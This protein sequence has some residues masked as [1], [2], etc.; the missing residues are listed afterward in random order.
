[1]SSGASL[2][3][4]CDCRALAC[5]FGQPAQGGEGNKA[6]AKAHYEKG[7]RLYEIREYDK[8][9]LEYKSAYLAQPDPAF[10]STSASAIESSARTKRRSISFGNT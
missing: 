7:T 8:A 1:M 3:C 2:A 6:T 4:G 10:Y 9:L 5:E